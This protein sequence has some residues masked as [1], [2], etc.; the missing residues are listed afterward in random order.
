M[1]VGGHVVTIPFL[2]TTIQGI[3]DGTTAVQRRVAGLLGTRSLLGLRGFAYLFFAASLLWYALGVVRGDRSRERRRPTVRETGRNGHLAVVALTG[4]IVLVATASMAGAGGVQRFEVVSSDSDSPGL[5][6]IST[7]DTE[8]G[9][10]R[11]PNS[12]FLPIVTYLEPASDGID[13][14]P[15]SLDIDARSAASVTVGISVPAENGVYRR[16]FVEHRYFA[17]LPDGITRTLYE[18][19]PWLPIIAIDILIGIPFY[20]LGRFLLGTGYVRSRV[21]SRDLSI[22]TRLVRR[23]KSLYRREFDA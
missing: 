15:R 20:L 11:I 16:Y 6:V 14:R 10:F 7:G 19:H 22:P 2:G 23:V 5:G 18:R 17:L 1:R 8:R 12:G 9:S 4:L 3:R 21:R 13:V